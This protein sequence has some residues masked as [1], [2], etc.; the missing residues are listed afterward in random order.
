MS[1]RTWMTSAN[2]S[3]PTCFQ[4]YYSTYFVMFVIVGEMG[5]LPV[6]GYLL[7]CPSYG[8]RHVHNYVCDT[9]MPRRQKSPQETKV[10]HDVL[11][12]K[13]A[14]NPPRSL[15]VYKHDPPSHHALTPSASPLLSGPAHYFYTLTIYVTLY[16]A[17]LILFYLLFTNLPHPP[18]L[19]CL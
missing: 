12:F 14:W 19:L 18:L 10:L 15:N 1:L 4:L 5:V 2:C 8:L 3:W 13:L 11:H 17:L 7:K 9:Q 16:L 6:R